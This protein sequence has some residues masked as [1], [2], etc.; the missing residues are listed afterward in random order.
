[1]FLG[2]T[3]RE[4]L[5]FNPLCRLMCFLDLINSIVNFFFLKKKFASYGQ[6]QIE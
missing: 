3:N 2:Y 1:M 4:I 5:R 6:F